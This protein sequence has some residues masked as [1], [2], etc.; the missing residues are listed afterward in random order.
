M[1]NIISSE[2]SIRYS[3]PEIA[4]VSKRH[5]LVNKHTLRKLSHPDKYYINDMYVNQ[6]ADKI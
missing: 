4:K 5:S 2:Q 3:K 1:N 6:N